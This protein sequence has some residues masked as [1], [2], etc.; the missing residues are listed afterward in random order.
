MQNKIDLIVNT[1]SDKAPDTI[2]QFNLLCNTTEEAIAWELAI[3]HIV[4]AINAYNQQALHGA[5][6][7][8]YT[9]DDGDGMDENEAF[10]DEAMQEEKDKA[11]NIHARGNGLFDAVVGEESSFII[12]ALDPLTQ[13]RLGESDATMLQSI[14]NSD[15]DRPRR[16]GG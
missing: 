1:S 9:D 8:G 10:D 5:D 11:Q 16:V 6:A 14:H 2:R 7:M 3:Q 13:E 12:E 4:D 15:D